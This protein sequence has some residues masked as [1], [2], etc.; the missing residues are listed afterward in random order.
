MKSI[1]FKRKTLK[2]ILCLFIILITFHIIFDNLLNTS[3][4]NSS[5]I[6]NFLIIRNSNGNATRFEDITYDEDVIWGNNIAFSLNFTYT[7]DNGTT[8]NPILDP[9]A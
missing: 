7:E 6:D 8:W 9:K 1:N 5:K 2:K 4:V 3:Y